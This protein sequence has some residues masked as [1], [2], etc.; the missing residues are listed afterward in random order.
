MEN[1]IRLF[2]FRILYKLESLVVSATQIYDA[3]LGKRLYK[4]E[5]SI[6]HGCVTRIDRLDLLGLSK[7]T[8]FHV[9]FLEMLFAVVLKYVFGGLLYKVYCARRVVGG[10]VKRVLSIM[11]KRE[12][13]NDLY[14]VQFFNGGRILVR[15]PFHQQFNLT[16]Y[17]DNHLPHVGHFYHDKYLMIAVNGVKDATPFYKLHASSFTENLDITASEFAVAALMY[18]NYPCTRGHL[19]NILLHPE[20]RVTAID[21]ETLEERVFKAK[22]VV[23]L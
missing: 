13:G 20:T 23:I 21:S 7:Q 18:T 14:S 22:D 1:R 4:A 8:L 10:D 3:T 2:A 5:K 17:L 19:L 6:Y 11:D 15:N 12:I 9:N 16:G